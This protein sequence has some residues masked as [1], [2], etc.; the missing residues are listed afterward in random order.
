[1]FTFGSYGQVL[2]AVHQSVVSGKKTLLTRCYPCSSDMNVRMFQ[3]A[4]YVLY[5]T[6]TISTK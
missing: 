5:N 6:M 4:F 2:S 3:K 1:M